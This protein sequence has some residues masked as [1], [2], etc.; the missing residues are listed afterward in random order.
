MNSISNQAQLQLIFRFINFGREFCCE[1]CK[2]AHP[3]SYL[4]E[5]FMLKLIALC[6][7]IKLLVI[8]FSNLLIIFMEAYWWKILNIAWTLSHMTLCSL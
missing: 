5:Y 2:F 1:S 6:K 3:N 4:F 7:N 8:G